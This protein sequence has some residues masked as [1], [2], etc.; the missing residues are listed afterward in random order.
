MPWPAPKVA[1][2]DGDGRSQAPCSAGGCWY[3]LNEKHPGTQKGPVDDEMMLLLHAL[4]EVDDRTR[5]WR[6]GTARGWE[7]MGDV[8]ELQ[9]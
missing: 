3:Y 9:L 4:G 5:V 2:T 7:A 8:P 6:D 1:A